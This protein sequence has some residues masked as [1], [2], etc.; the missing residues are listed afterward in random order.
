MTPAPRAVA[1]TEGPAAP[2]TV[3]L[4]N[5]S[6]LVGRIEL[7]PRCALYLA[8]DLLQLVVAKDCAGPSWRLRNEGTQ[9][10][11]GL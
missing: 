1:T 9:G 2:V 4:F 6:G 7:S 11:R 10:A 5:D 8:L 3:S